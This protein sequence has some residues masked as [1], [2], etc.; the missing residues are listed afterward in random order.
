MIYVH[1]N[2][3]SPVPSLVSL[4]GE[5]FWVVMHN[6][7]CMFQFKFTYGY[8]FLLPRMLRNSCPHDKFWKTNQTVKITRSSFPI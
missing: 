7:N 8:S 5:G 6:F 3:L 2:G 1:V 4:G